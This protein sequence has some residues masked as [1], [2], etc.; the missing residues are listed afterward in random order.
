M[1]LKKRLLFHFSKI[2]HAK[3]LT[4]ELIE[5]FKVPDMWKDEKIEKKKKNCSFDEKKKI[6]IFK[7]SC[8]L[9]S[10]INDSYFKE[11][12]FSLGNDE[13]GKKNFALDS[14]GCNLDKL[15]DKFDLSDN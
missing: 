6:N 9:D 7:N 3:I 13:S 11:S 15:F 1:K 10:L 5:L 2:R 12:N 14:V 4:N 8:D